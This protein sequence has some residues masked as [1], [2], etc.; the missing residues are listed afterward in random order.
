MVRILLIG[1]GSVGRGFLK[2]ISRKMEWL[3]SAGID[4]VIVGV[5]DSKGGL[6]DENGLDPEDVLRKKATGGFD[7]SISSLDLIEKVDFDVGIETTPTNAE[8]GEPGLTH[9]KKML[10]RGANV[11]T[12][13][14]GPLIVD[15]HGLCGFAKKRGLSLKYEATVGGAMP[16]ISLIEKT[17]AGNE[18]YS[19]EGIFN[20]TCN[21]ILSRMEKEL[22][23]F[24][25]V[26]LEAQEL[27][28]AEKDPSYDIEGIDTAGKLV[29]LAN[30]I[31]DMKVGM[32]DVEIRGI[33]EI[34]PE[35]MELATRNGY[36]IRLIGEVRKNTGKLRVYPRL[37]SKSHPL[38]IYGTLNAALVKTDLAGEVFVSGRGAGSI[39]TASAILND[40]IGLY[41]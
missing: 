36:T 6:Y 28:I 21:Y 17:L 40:L 23:P 25:H 39:E 7:N 11:I 16:L 26:L 14:K 31:M 12:S 32:K 35:A 10:E 24:S 8:T 33:S 15:F 3:R 4:P 29:I 19:I 30:A 37:V 2:V 27:G 22:F 34:T 1:C 18:V 5:T 9:I 20:G 13:N 41:S 38:A